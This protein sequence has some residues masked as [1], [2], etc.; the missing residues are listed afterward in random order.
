[1]CVLRDCVFIFNFLSW[2]INKHHFKLTPASLLSFASS[3]CSKAYF[4]EQDGIFKQG[5]SKKNKK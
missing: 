3:F 1:M 4:I 5:K 2:L